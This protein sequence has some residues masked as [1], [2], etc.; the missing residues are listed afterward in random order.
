MVMCTHRPP[1]SQWND[2]WLSSLEWQY[3]RENTRLIAESHLS[4]IDLVQSAVEVS[5]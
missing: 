5:H 3:G 1:P 2:D 4:A